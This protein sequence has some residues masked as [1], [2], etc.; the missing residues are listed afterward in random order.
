M[1]YR[2]S[3]RASADLDAITHYGLET[4]G[5]QT[6]VSYGSGLD[7]LFEL[8][9]DNHL[10][11]HAWNDEHEIR[12]HRYQSHWVYYKIRDNQPLIL[13][14]LHTSRLAPSILDLE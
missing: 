2:L 9:A 8:L 11:G 14:V 12:R 6:V 10:M 3:Q 13:R 4:F 7:Y 1:R 5:E